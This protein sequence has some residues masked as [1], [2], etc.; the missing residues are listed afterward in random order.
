[1]IDPV[2]RGTATGESDVMERAPPQCR[3]CIR[4]IAID[5]SAN[6]D[7]PRQVPAANIKA[8]LGSRMLSSTRRK[9][10]KIFLDANV[11]IRAGKPPGRPV[12]DSLADLVTSGFIK[13]LTTDLTKIEVAKHHANRDLEE[14]AGLGRD[15]FRKLVQQAV[16]V[17]LPNISPEELRKKI[18]DRYVANTEKMFKDLAAT[19]LSVDEVKPST[20]FESYTHKTGVFGAE[21][22]KDQ[23]PDAFIFERL[24]SE[25]QAHDNLIIVSDDRDFAAAV[26]SAD[27]IRNVRSIADL[28][29][30]L[31]LKSEAAPDVGAFFE[32]HQDEVRQVVDD[33]INS[34][35]LQVSD[36]EDAEIDE[37]SVKR[38]DFLE[39]KTYDATGPEG[40]ILV[41]GSMKMTVDVS[42]THPDW[43]RSIYDSEDKVR[44]AFDTVTGE[45]EVELEA[46][47]AMTILVD[48]NKT[49]EQIDH[50]A[51]SNDSFIWVEL[52]ECDDYR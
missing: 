32:S 19:T 31:G 23:F 21:A 6:L 29:E 4:P 44:V 16:G 8:Y 28:F 14:V 2:D 18:F 45:K 7:Y 34:W 39:F 5:E 17:K 27:H 13:V 37:S 3:R 47:F 25:G 42:Y 50:F 11:V 48:D 36:I 33:E 24:R 15:R 9:P 40:Q 12:M 38:V 46:D 43:D 10:Q 52:Q 1:M 20:V 26:K 30:E 49:P 22:K 51:F 35:G 41:V